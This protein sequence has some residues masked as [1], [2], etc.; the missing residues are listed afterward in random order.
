M[1][2]FVVFVVCCCCFTLVFGMYEVEAGNEQSNGGEM[3]NKCV[4]KN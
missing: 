1:V 3:K 2:Y 4:G